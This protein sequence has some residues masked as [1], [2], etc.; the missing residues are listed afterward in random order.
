MYVLCVLQHPYPT[1]DEKRQIAAQT[2]LTLLQVNN[3][4]V[5]HV[6]FSFDVLIHVCC[7]VHILICLTNHSQCLWHCQL[8][9]QTCK[10]IVSQEIHNVSNLTRP[11]ANYWCAISR[12]ETGSCGERSSV[13]CMCDVCCLA[14][15]SHVLISFDNLIHV[16][17]LVHILI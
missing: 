17:C 5:S 4:L 13:W 6:P 11:S 1:E 14:S 15:L 2:N 7:L 12:T 16:H 8:G 3:W 9:H 10:N